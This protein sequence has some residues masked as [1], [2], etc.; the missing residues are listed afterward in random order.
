MKVVAVVLLLVAALFGMTGGGKAEARDLSVD[1]ANAERRVSSYEA[2]VSMRRRQLGS[3]VR[4]YRAAARR[5]NPLVRA[6][7]EN[8]AELRRLYSDLADREEAAGSR[9]SELEQ[10]RQEEIDEHD[11]EVRDGVGIGLAALV[12]G[13][14][15]LAWGWFRATALVA[16]LTRA[17]RGQAIGVCVGGGLLMVVIG[18]VLGSSR[19]VVGALGSFLFWLGLILPTALLLARHSA[20][21]QRGRSRPLLR[22][23]R[24]PVWT[25]PAIASLMFVLF[26]ASTGSA[27]FADGASS[28]PVSAELREEAEATS[29][30]RGAEELRAAQEQVAEAKLRAANPLSRRNSARRALRAARRGFHG[31][32]RRLVSARRSEHSVSQ[33]LVA[34]EGRERREAEREAAREA[35]EAEEQAEIEAEELASQCNPN[36]SGC[37]DPYSPDYDCEGGSGDGPDYT[38]TVEVI[39]YDEY[40]L[41]AND[42]GIGCEE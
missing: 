41:D 22:R 35:R 20:E 10:Q 24:L 9:I 37:L 42:N 5:A 8:R 16:A 38:G 18:A 23:D 26:L 33:R 2:D 30:G 39:G 28:Q 31:A 12:A 4:R 13:L 14:I 17:E 34:L 36:Y 19:G 15:A 3:A 1:L 29:E 7:D 32:Q 21:V 11:E 40:G 27:I 6:L 25:S